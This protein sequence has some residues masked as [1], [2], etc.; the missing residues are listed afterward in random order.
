ML[1]NSPFSPLL[2]FYLTFL[3]ISLTPSLLQESMF[4]QHV[5]LLLSIRSSSPITFFLFLP[6]EQAFAIA[7]SLCAL[8]SPVS[9]IF[10]LSLPLLLKATCAHLFFSFRFFFPLPLSRFLPLSLCKR[11]HKINLLLLFTP[12]FC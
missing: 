12:F 4:R 5:Y 6:W 11:L 1:T 3:F 2:F 7:L 10:F 9:L 8:F